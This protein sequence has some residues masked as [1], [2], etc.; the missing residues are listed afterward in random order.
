MSDFVKPRHLIIDAIPYLKEIMGKGL[1]KDLSEDEEICPVCH[2]TGVKLANNI[3]GLQNE[4]TRSDG[5]F[6]PYKHQSLVRCN[7]CYNGIVHKCKY[8][9]KLLDKDTLECDCEKAREEKEQKI[10]KRK[11]KN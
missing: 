2:G 1:V 7:N 10:S 8:C 3:Y 9:G 6:F 11:L 5:V 4:P